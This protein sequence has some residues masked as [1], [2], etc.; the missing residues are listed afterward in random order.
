[1][2]VAIYIA[3]S[4]NGQIS[5]SRGVPDWLSPEYGSGFFEICQKTKAVIMGRKTYTILAPDYLPLKEE[6][7]TIVLTTNTKAK[8]ANRTVVFTDEG[9]KAIIAM[10]EQKGH[11]EAVIVGGAYAMTKFIEAN[12]VNEIILVVEPALF[13]KGLPMLNEIEFTR[14]LT[15]IG[16]TPLNSNTVKLHYAV[17][18]E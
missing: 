13:G 4:A 3:M 16:V 1:M 12:L 17:R 6:G 14:N 15:L 8:A 5:N 2:K 18:H 9:A 7:T 11:T 10:L